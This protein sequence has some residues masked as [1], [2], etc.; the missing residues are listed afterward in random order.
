MAGDIRSAIARHLHRNARYASSILGSEEL[1]EEIAQETAARALAH[2][3]NDPSEVDA[4]TRVVT[5][6]LALDEVRRR[7]RLADLEVPDEIDPSPGPVEIAERNDA[8]EI[9]LDALTDVPPDMVNLLWSYYIVGEKAPEIA[10]RLGVK[11]ATVRKR[12]E[13]ARELVRTRYD[14]LGG[15]AAA[16]PAALPKLRRS[17]GGVTATG[18]A[19]TGVAAGVLA[20][21]FVGPWVTGPGKAMRNHADSYDD[22]TSGADLQGAG[23]DGVNAV[24]ALLRTFVEKSPLGSHGVTDRHRLNPVDRLER[25]P[26][27]RSLIRDCHHDM[28]PSDVVC[29]KR[30]DDV[31]PGWHYVTITPPV[32]G[33]HRVMLHEIPIDR[34]CDVP[35]PSSL[36]HCGH[37]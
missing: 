1:G 13:R 16:F 11:P 21:P 8:I 14:K 30:D 29:A 22:S 15:P 5:K 28:R 26:L 37:G 32:G 9:L 10:E 4:W 24:Q 36:Y 7:Q 2:P 33:D 12:L 27:G 31:P 23:G 20:A 18:L 3:F 35:H 17:R 6:N 25:S 34:V 19:A